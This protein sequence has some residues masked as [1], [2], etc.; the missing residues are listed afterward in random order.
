MRS[1]SRVAL[2][3]TA[4][5]LPVLVVLVG[6]ALSDGPRQPRVPPEVSVGSSPGP[7][8]PVASSTTAPVPTTS[9]DL[10]PPPPDDDADD[11]EPD[12]D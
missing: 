12:D 4:L 3:I 5:A 1:A 9:R 7:T 8:A 2:L 10:P 11:D 6:V